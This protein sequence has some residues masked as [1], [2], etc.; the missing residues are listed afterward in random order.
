MIKPEKGD[1][2]LVLNDGQEL[3]VRE[4]L[5]IDEYN[6]E[7]IMREHP[8]NVFLVAL[9]KAESEYAEDRAKIE[10]KEAELSMKFVHAKVSLDIR[11]GII[12]VGA[13]LTESSVNEAATTNKAY[14]DSCQRFIDASK[15]NAMKKRDRNYAEGLLT[16][17]EHRKTMLNSLSANWRQEIDSDMKNL[18]KKYQKM[19]DDIER[20]EKTKNARKA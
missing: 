2:K 5:G 8:H 15:K 14:Y 1:Y 16:A 19:S 4:L 20:K 9:H 11:E 18:E 17:M 13:K 6:S 10:V 12:P 7:K 3:S